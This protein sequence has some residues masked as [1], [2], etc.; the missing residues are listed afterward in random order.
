MSVPSRRTC[1]RSGVSR[2]RMTLRSTVFPLPLSPSRVTVSPRWM[3]R[4]MPFRTGFG[5][6]ARCTSRTS[7]AGSSAGRGD[8]A[9]AVPLA[10]RPWCGGRRARAKGGPRGRGGPRPTRAARAP[11]GAPGGA[12]SMD[13]SA[14]LAV[15]PHDGAGD[16]RPRPHTPSGREVRAARPHA[17]NGFTEA[18]RRARLSRHGPD[19]LRRPTAVRLVAPPSSEN[20]ALIL[21]ARDRGCLALGH[22][23]E[24]T[25][26][27]KLSSQSPGLLQELRAEGAATC[28]VSRPPDGGAAG[29]RRVPARELVPGDVIRLESGDLVPPTRVCSGDRPPNGRAPLTGESVPVE[30][31]PTREPAGGGISDRH[32][33]FFRR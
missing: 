15:G 26:S 20:P 18:G 1:P 25:A 13:G 2:P 9:G 31:R 22:T 16:H 11:A 24:A 10:M 28:A 12:A 19:R 7:I 29:G 8:G 14:A 23:V 30:S 5:P 32:G 27:I 21:P 6:K 33:M 3:R 4:S 17:T